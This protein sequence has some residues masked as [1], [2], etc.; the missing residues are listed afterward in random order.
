M[1]ESWG[2]NWAPEAHENSRQRRPSLNGSE[3]KNSIDHDP[4]ASFPS[5]GIMVI[6][7]QKHPDWPSQ[8]E[9]VEETVSNDPLQEISKTGT[10]DRYWVFIVSS[11]FQIVPCATT[12]CID[13]GSIRERKLQPI[14]AMLCGKMVILLI[15]WPWN[16]SQKRLRRVPTSVPGEDHMCAKKP[17]EPGWT[18][19]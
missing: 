9:D 11:F 16:A 15:V 5:Q 3:E 7:E 13:E 1:R 6:T 17:R 12:S 18:S 19:I 4:E 8:N 14:F 10:T 2:P